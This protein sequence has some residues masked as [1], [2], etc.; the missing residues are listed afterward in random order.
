MQVSAQ[1]AVSYDPNWL[2]LW[3][4]RFEDPLSDAETF[5]INADKQVLEIGN[6]PLTIK[7]IQGQFMGIIL[8]TPIGWS[9]FKRANSNY[10]G[11]NIDQMQMTEALQ[12]VIQLG[13][14]PL[15]GVQYEGLWGELDSARDLSLYETA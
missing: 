13:E 2:D 4:R 11:H 10:S 5:L 1:I 12:R 9:F 14:I 6:K 8:F 3:S 7:E 15:V